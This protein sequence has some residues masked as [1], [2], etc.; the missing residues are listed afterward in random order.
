MHDI[1]FTVAPKTH[2][3]FVAALLEPYITPEDHWMLV[4]HAIFQNV[5]CLPAHDDR[6]RSSAT[7]GGATRPSRCTAEFVA[8][9]DQDTMDPNYDNMPMEAFEPMVQSL[10]RQTAA[11]GSEVE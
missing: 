8:K 10:V 5:H 4:H 6:P 11:A 2:G 9:F 3:Q 7:N 1:G